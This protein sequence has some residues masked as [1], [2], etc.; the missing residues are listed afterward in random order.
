VKKSQQEINP[1]LKTKYMGK[2]DLRS[3]IVNEA[4]IV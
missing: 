4:F 1:E 2:V 3:H